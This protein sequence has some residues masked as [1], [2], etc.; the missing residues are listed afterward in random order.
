MLTS[1]KPAI[2]ANKIH[3]EV[4]NNE[5]DLSATISF[6]PAVISFSIPI[7]KPKMLM[8][9]SNADS[10]IRMSKMVDIFKLL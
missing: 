8:R 7:I 6:P 2:E 3:P 10:K 5:R 1:K 9:N 4:T